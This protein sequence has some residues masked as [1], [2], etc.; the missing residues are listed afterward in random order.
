MYPA[1]LSKEESTKNL[2]EMFKIMKVVIIFINVMIIAIAVTE[3]QLPD[4]GTKIFF[5]IVLCGVSWLAYFCAKSMAD[6]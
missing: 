2:K 3:K 6:E 1:Q 4:I 5:S